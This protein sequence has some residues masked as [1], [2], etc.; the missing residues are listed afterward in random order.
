M[1][2]ILGLFDYKG[3]KIFGKLITTMN[4]KF[5]FIFHQM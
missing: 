4:T 3:K 1:N 2:T 5:L